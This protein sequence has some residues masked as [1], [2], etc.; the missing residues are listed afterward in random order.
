[1][2]L[3]LS[4]IVPHNT[5]EAQSER[6]RLDADFLL[7]GESGPDGTFTATISIAPTLVIGRQPWQ[8]LADPGLD[9]LLLPTDATIHFPAGAGTD[10]LVPLALA[11]AHYKLGSYKAAADAAWG[12]QETLNDTGAS[13][14]FARLVEAQ[15]RLAQGDYQASVSAV[16]GMEPYSGLPVEAL[17]TRALARFYRDDYDASLDE[18]NRVI[19]DRNASN[20]VL[21][22]A[23]LLRARLR[24]TS[25]FLTQAL[26]DLQD[27][28]RLDPDNPRVNLA[29]AEV[30][31]RQARPS[32]AAAELAA[33][34]KAQPDAAPGY[35]LLGLVR[36][37]LGQPEEALKSLDQSSQIYAGWLTSLRAEEARASAL[38]DPALSSAATYAIL[39]INKEQAAVYLYEGMALADIARKEPPESFLGGLW[40]GI[41]GEPATWERALAKMQEAARLDPRRP[42]IPLQ[43]G[44]LYTQQQDYASAATM[45]QQ[46]R[47]LDPSAPEPY[48]ALSRLQEAQGSSNEAIATLSDLIAHSPRYFE[49]YEQSA[50]LYTAAGDPASAAS[51]LERAVAVPPQTSTDHLWRGKFLTTLARPAE[52]E[53]E[54]RTAGQDPELWEA[55]LLLG[56]LLV[57]AGRS[58]EALAEFQVVLAAQPNNETA[59]LSAGQLLVLAGKQEEAQTL[60]ERLTS[61]APG[62]V[63]GHIALLQLLL[64]KGDNERA[65]AE[66]KRAV[67]AGDSRSDSHYFLGLAYESAFQRHEAST[68]YTTATTRDPNNFQAFLS[69]S[70]A[71]FKEDRYIESIAAADQASAL[72]AGDPQPYLWKAHSQL[73]LTDVGGALSTLGTLLDLKPDDAD[74]LALTSRAY[75]AKGDPTSA[76]GYAQQAKAAAP[77][78]PAGALAL[79]EFY[80]TEGRSADATQSFGPLLEMGDSTSQ[81]LAMTG[82]G[83]AYSLEGDTGKALNEYSAAAARDPSAAEPYLYM[84]HLYVQTG[85]WDAAAAAYRRAVQLRPN[86]PLAL[87]YLGKA[88]LQRKDLQNAQAAYARAVTYSPN[89]V[90]AWFGLGIAQRDQGHAKEAIE[91]LTRATQLNSGYAD[92][93]LYLGLTY[94]ESGQR[95]L[96]A[97]AFEHARTTTADAALIRQAED[98]LARVR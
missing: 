48:M 73:G 72:R 6:A 45:L 49:A 54:L 95:A 14:Q 5:Q 84:G 24:Y 93:W 34:F 76:L 91:A 89:M 74:A 86:W 64:A 66:G 51:I 78:N 15:S 83:R 88:L 35:R 97:D 43:M 55:H 85:K 68:E 8:E 12:A 2:D 20:R 11:L 96:A 69:L 39:Q 13:G 52:A 42:D 61:T 58:P 19:G 22:S 3:L 59:L 31:Y 46:A 23:Y 94:E 21:A 30:L 47:D 44:S 70:R 53:S 90:E 4:K 16:T 63:D 50:R 36:L 81:A 27:S 77:N 32:D 28:A 87:Y 56:S 7:W 33:L 18:C 40:R 57:A 17:L 38:G 62:N 65:I 10:P 98:G 75:A 79:G 37:M 1:V 9:L 60:F 71:L 29:K 67:A 80:L 82:L 26:A 92:A 41:R 25:G